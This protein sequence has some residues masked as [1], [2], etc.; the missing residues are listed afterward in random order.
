MLS[1]PILDFWRSG[2]IN[3]TMSILKDGRTQQYMQVSMR[4]QSGLPKQNSEEP[5]NVRNE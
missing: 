4:F 1:Y 5:K 3:N 2:N